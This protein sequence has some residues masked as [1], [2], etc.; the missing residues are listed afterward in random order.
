MLLKLTHAIVFSV[1]LALGATVIPLNTYADEG[2]Q[3]KSVEASIDSD[4]NPT[5]E[6]ALINIEI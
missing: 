5:F 1:T 3:P 6:Q 4:K 2:T